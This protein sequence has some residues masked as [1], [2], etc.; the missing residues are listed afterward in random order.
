LPAYWRG[1]LDE[2]TSRLDSRNELALKE[3]IRHA[4]ERC[5]VLMIAHRLSTVVDAHQIVVLD[6]GAVKGIGTHEELYESNPL[7]RELAQNQLVGVANG[8]QDRGG[9]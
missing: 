6:R 1:L 2:V 8:R 9:R 7:Y 4:S 3:S 5:T